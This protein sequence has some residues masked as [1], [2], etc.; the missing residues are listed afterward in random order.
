MKT[1]KEIY[2]HHLKNSIA[3][4]GE[5]VKELETVIINLAMSGELAELNDQFDENDDM[6]FKYEDFR[7][8]SDYNVRLLYC[9]Y[10]FIDDK[11]KEIMNVN[12]LEE[13]ELEN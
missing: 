5:T 6:T 4:L 1:N 2:Q 12:G 8:L 7:K 10:D 11:R 13:E 3:V 9:L